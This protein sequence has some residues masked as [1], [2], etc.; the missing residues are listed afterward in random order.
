MTLKCRYDH[1]SCQISLITL[2]N[3]MVNGYLDTYLPAQASGVSQHSEQSKDQNTVV[4]FSVSC[5]LIA[6]NAIYLYDYHP[7][8]LLAG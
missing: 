5:E 1:Q 3:L 7:K 6:L 8:F 4:I 2:F